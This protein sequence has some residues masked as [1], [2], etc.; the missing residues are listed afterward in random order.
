[1][2]PLALFAFAVALWALSPVAGARQ[3]SVRFSGSDVPLTGE[4]F[5]PASRDD[6]TSRHPAVVL[7]HGCSGMYTARGELARRHHDWA[8]RFAAWGFV[9]L[10]VDSLQ[11]RGVGPLC[12]LEDKDRPIHPWKE[13][14]MDAY[15]A[16]DFLASR[17]DVDRRNVFVMGW[18]HGGSTVVGVVRSDAPGRRA[19]GPRFK[20]A[21]AYY[22]GCERPLRAKSYRPTVPLLIQ[23][24]E[25]D[26]W[27]PAAPCAEL[28]RKM[29]RAGLPVHTIIYP[30]AHHGFDAPDTKLRVLP[31][32]YNPRAP[33]ER[34]A[35]VG[36]HEPSRIKAIADTKR[37][38]DQQLAR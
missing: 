15:A 26:D 11:P 32:V 25:A 1:M 31:N 8:Q 13:R 27:V 20:A 35:H 7:M 19:D 37:F 24:G 30:E 34:G 3:E 6:K 12:E 10:L 14:T 9:V 18:S 5:L 4:L 23:H 2:N 36:T 22:P 38:V 33:G 17:A 16:L 29:Q 21:I 28:A